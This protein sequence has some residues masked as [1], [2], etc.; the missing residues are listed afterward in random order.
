MIISSLKLLNFR[1]YSTADNSLFFIQANGIIL[2]GEV[3]EKSNIC[4]MGYKSLVS[5]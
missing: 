5:K 3:G 4:E 2:H 1:K